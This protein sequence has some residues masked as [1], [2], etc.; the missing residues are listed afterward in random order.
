VKKSNVPHRPATSD[1]VHDAVPLDTAFDFLNTLELENG[2]L[3]ERLSSLDTAVSWL[4]DAG[5]ASDTTAITGRA[6]SASDREA[7]L[8]RLITTR[9]AL[10]DVAHAVAHE[11]APPRSAIDEVNRALASRER[12]ELVAADDGVRLG[13]SHV[14]EPVDDVLARI[15]EPIVREIG[16]GHDDRIRICANDTCAW[17]FYDESR[18]GR[19]RWCDMATCGNRAKAQRHR[20]R[21]KDAAEPTEGA[22]QSV[23]RSPA[24]AS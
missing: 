6:R 22:Q 12:I 1:H 14:G 8:R 17:L 5:V 11:E 15:A 2:A 13:H 9:T 10:R 3:V 21:Q 4:V 23:R 19:R 16:N 7:V 20:E 18:A 24:P